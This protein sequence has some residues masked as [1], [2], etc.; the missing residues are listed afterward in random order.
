MAC[1]T[2]LPPEGHPVS[3]R[4]QRG[5]TP[6]ILAILSICSVCLLATPAL[7]QRQV[8]AELERTDRILE[9]VRESVGNSAGDRAG[10]VL[11]QATRVQAEAWERFRRG[12]ASIAAR[13]TMKARDLARRALETAEID[14]KGHERIRDLL[15]STR[16][17]VERTRSAVGGR[18]DPQARRL[19]DVGVAQL[20]K[21]SEAYRGRQYRRAMR[22]A[23]TA[24]E[25]IQRA[26]DRSQG[27]LESAALS[28]E[29]AME[30]TDILLEEVRFLLDDE[31]NQRARRLYE[32]AFALQERAIERGR[33]G[34][35]EVAARLSRQARASALAALLD[36][37]RSRDPEDVEEVVSAVGQLLLEQSPEIKASGSQAALALLEE[38]RMRH[39]AAEESLSRGDLSSALESAR[40][41]E[42]L[43][44]R[45]SEAAGSR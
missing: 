4:G 13:L 26:Y 28:A 6:A 33:A 24:R 8:R 12:N 17:L 3:R 2:D 25:L 5:L 16:D 23:V 32:E 10:T 45:S 43:L 34:Q 22:L 37:S 38:A 42:G 21:A 18:G 40:V 30:R 35:R 1:G 39:E 27:G 14:T 19:L 44:R 20:H 11:R 41:A 36:L 29:R 31:S 9:R 15:D 7:A